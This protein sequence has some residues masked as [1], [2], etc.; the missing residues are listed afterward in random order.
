MGLPAGACA[1]CGTKLTRDGA[2]FCDTCGTRIAPTDARGE[3][4]QVTVLFADVVGSMDIASRL[5]PER[6]R[7]IMTAVFDRC[8]AA[9]RRYGG[10]VDKFTGDGIMALFGAPIALEDHAL[11]G[12]LAAL[13]IQQETAPLAAEIAGRDRV[14]LRLRVGLDSSRVVAGG[15][16]S[17]PNNYTAVGEHVG[18][19][20]RMEY[21]APP[22]GV[23]VSE[24]TARLV[25]SVAV[26]G[27]PEL[28]RIKG[29]AAPVPARRLAAIGADPVLTGRRKWSLVGRMGD[30]R[31][32]RHARRVDRR[33]GTCGRGGREAGH[34]Q[35]PARARDRRNRQ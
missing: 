21:A 33:T 16:G 22:G 12:C 11:R 34:R 14:K 15:I 3:Y 32:E 9:V 6:F 29:T 18:M 2:L 35:N 7:E 31:A 10:T 13:G 19:A 27:Q 4:K 30:E 23:M 24:S 5:D 8:T 26:L 17:S 1:V 28:V 20:Q 25:E